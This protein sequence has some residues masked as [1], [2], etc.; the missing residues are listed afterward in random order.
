M[1]R[2]NCRILLQN[3]VPPCCACDSVVAV[4][5]PAALGRW[6]MVAS[7]VCGKCQVVCGK[8]QVV[9][10]EEIEGD[11]DECGCCSATVVMMLAILPASSSSYIKE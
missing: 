5:E 1:V 3:I 11:K 6:E 8:C 10:G 9:C 4:P 2:G 7:E